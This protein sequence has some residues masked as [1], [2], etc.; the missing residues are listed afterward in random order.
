MCGFR[1]FHIQYI[2]IWYMVARGSP[3]I[4]IYLFIFK[5]RYTVY[6][7]TC[8]ALLCAPT[9]K[10]LRYHRNSKKKP[11]AK[12]ATRLLRYVGPW[13][14]RTFLRPVFA[15]PPVGGNGWNFAS[16]WWWKGQGIEAKCQHL[17]GNSPPFGGILIQRICL[18]FQFRDYPPWN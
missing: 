1:Y 2:Y 6:I 5:F 4:Y 3:P 10:P 16:V 15:K 9:K 7:Y 11:L 12:K 13:T 8:S 18:E 14:F 17:G